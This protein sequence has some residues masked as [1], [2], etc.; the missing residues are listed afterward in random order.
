[1][2]QLYMIALT[3][4]LSAGL[5]VA[6]DD[7]KGPVAPKASTSMPVVVQDTK[8]GGDVAYINGIAT[9]SLFVALGKYGFLKAHKDSL[10]AMAFA[11]LAYAVAQA[12]KLARAYRSASKEGILNEQC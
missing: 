6:V 9:S 10:E 1:M 5:L 12:D 4:L 11:F 8:K 3:S 7:Q 2:K